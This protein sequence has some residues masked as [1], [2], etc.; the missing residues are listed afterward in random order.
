[1]IINIFTSALSYKTYI[2]TITISYFIFQQM[3]KIIIII[4]FKIIV[5]IIQYSSKLNLCQIVIF[6]KPSNI[7][8][9]NI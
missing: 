2:I 7:I 4:N 6:S 3:L 1:M 5:K 9:T 8:A